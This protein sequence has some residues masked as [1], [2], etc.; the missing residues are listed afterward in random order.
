MKRF[1]IF[2]LVCATTVLSLAQRNDWARFNFYSSAN[3]SLEKAPSVVFMG[4]SITENWGDWRPQF[5]K[6]HNFVS[7]GISGQTTCQMVVRFHADVVDLNPKAVVI[8]AGT[9]DIAKNN[10]DISLK[11]VAQNIESMCE[12]AKAHKI[13][14]VICTVTPCKR[15]S[16]RPELEN[17][18]DSIVELNRMLQSYAVKNHITYVDFWTPMAAEDKG[19]RSELAEDGCHPNDKGY[20]IMEAILLKTLRKLGIKSKK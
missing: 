6:D 11:H 3:A 5:F 4:N 20:D 18:A 15:Y 19:M 1:L 10:G 12:I 14:P 8:M 7:R 9:N 16:W 13:K 2:I 17:V